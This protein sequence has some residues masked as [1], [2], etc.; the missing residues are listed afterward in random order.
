MLATEKAPHLFPV[1]T[2]CLVGIAA[3]YR[4]GSRGV[5]VRIPVGI[6]FSSSP[7]RPHQLWGPPSLICNVSP[8]V[9][10]MG[11][12]VDHSPPTSAEVKNT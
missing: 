2:T 6:R 4:L 7:H 5:G 11:R 3:G 10:R 12:E 1:F 8:G 9:K